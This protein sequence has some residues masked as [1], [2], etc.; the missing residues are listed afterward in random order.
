M[1]SISTL[2]F[3][4][5][6]SSLFSQTAAVRGVLQDPEGGAVEFANVALF[7]AADSSLYKVE[8]TNEAGVFHLRNLRAG[9]FYLKSTYL[10]FGDL[11]QGGIE[12]KDQPLDLGILKFSPGATELAEVTVTATR[13]LVEIRPDRTVFNV[14]GTINSVGSDAIS[15]LRKAPSVTVDNNNNITVLG[16]SG[17]LLY[18]DGKRLP[19]SGDDLTNYLENLTADQID[20]IEIITNPG[21]RYE[22]EG[23]AG[24]IDIRLKK[25]KNHG[26]N[27]SVSTTYSQGRYHR[28]NVSSS[29]NYRNRLLNAFGTLGGNYNK[30]YM[31]M[32]F[33]SYQNG[34]VLDEIN[35]HRFNG[36]N[37]NYRLGTDFF[38]NKKHTVGFLVSGGQHDGMPNSYNRIALSEQN[39]P[40]MIDSILVAT[41]SV[42]L[43]RRQRTY[44]VNYRFDN[45][46]GRNM[47]LDLDYGK[48]QNETERYQPNRYYNA[49]ETQVLTEVINSFDTPTDI[50]IY[51][52]KLD[53]E[54]KF[55]G[56]TLG[57]GAKLTQVVSDNTFLFYDELGNGPVR[58]DFR[59]NLFD[60]DERVY[61]GYVNFAREL[62]TAWSF[63]AGLRAEQTDATGMLEAF[64]PELQEPPVEFNYLSWFPSGG[65]TW[66]LAPKH[67][68]ALNYGRRINRPDYNV[69]NPFNDQISQLSYQKGN[70]FLRPEI[71][72]NLELGYTLAYR[73]NFKLAYS[74]TT[75]QITRLIAPDEDDPRA[76][77]I[78]WANLADQTIVS[79]NVSAPVQIL[80]KWNAY[81]NVSGSYLDNQADYGDGAIV[82]VQAFT[83]N[84]YQQHTFDLPAGFKGEIS[85]YYS[86]PGVWGGVFLYESS[87]SL[88]LGLQRKFFQD[89]LNVRLSF[90]DLFYESGWDGYSEFNGLLAYGGGNWD[91]RRASLSLSY[92]FGNQNVRSRKRQT[93]IEAE[94]GRVGS[95]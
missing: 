94:A 89:R 32:N 86:G 49:D 54:D 72:N 77:F 81:F 75:D 66:K 87:W 62:G 70:P 84:I 59:S 43:M 8:T 88:D 41:S 57:A 3:F 73:Y 25:D 60:Y 24:I 20:R 85:G 10:G 26:A 56:G 68:L 64:R 45:G 17:V 42:E 67:T 39:T 37:Y 78:T 34:L 93:G 29:G 22:A 92:Q 79:F 80:K 4:L 95:E 76:G 31:D 18:V 82:D 52:A 74:R 36:K 16:R 7:N 58:N 15:L 6:I 13:A 65:L 21:A 33:L 48:F 38:L 61:A 19:L 90:S 83:Y 50:D 53:F 47:I 44:N 55:L 71:V 1:R 40:D 35:N 27:G 2:S 91:S 9:T 11:Y 5:F 30:G 28:A 69:L 12:L 14:S 63:S 23:N 46:R 51:S